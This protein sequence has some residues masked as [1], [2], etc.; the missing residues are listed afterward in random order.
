[1]TVCI[2]S[3][4]FR[5][6]IFFYFVVLPGK[7]KLEVA[8][9]DGMLNSFIILPGVEDD[10]AIQVLTCVSTKKSLDTDADVIP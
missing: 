2:P 1:M 7:G 10:R 9:M 6:W 3:H 5:C 8:V 4:I